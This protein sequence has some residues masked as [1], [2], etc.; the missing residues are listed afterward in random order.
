MFPELSRTTLFC[1]QGF[2]SDALVWNPTCHNCPWD[3][4]A[5]VSLVEKGMKGVCHE[6]A[7]P[8]VSENIDGLVGSKWVG[9]FSRSVGDFI[10]EFVI[11]SKLDWISA[12][13]LSDHIHN[14][15]EGLFNSLCIVMLCGKGQDS[16]L[17]TLH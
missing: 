1:L 17:L 10:A 16:K 4:G 8:D 14:G 13:S 7:V 15:S 9:E 6:W 5:V 3:L 12:C 11:K 2:N